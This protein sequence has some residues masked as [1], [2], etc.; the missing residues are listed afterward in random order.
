[1]SSQAEIVS[2]ACF[3]IGAALVVIGLLIGLYL[4]FRKTVQETKQRLEE[5][6]NDVRRQINSLQT[7]AVDAA[8]T[9]QANPA[10]A[11]AATG[12]GE[13]AKGSLE[14]IKDI[15]GSLPEAMRFPG[16]L[17]LVGSVL[18]SVATIQFGGHSIF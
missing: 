13:A 5:K 7:I 18:M 10:Q 3:V 11:T 1:M 6:A 17:I 4:T 2:W 9:A 15:I 12:A 16:L 14:Q 8:S